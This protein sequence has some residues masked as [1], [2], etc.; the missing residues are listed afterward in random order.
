MAEE[1][2][3]PHAP[4]HPE[5]V[6][7]CLHVILGEEWEHHRYAARDLDAIQAGTAT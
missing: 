4:E 7:S 3:N 5:T 2:R 6:L 1:R